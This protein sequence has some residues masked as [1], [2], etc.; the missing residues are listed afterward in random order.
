[1]KILIILIKFKNIKIF[2]LPSIANEYSYPTE[3]EIILSIEFI[4]DGIFL[5]SL[6]PIPN[7]PSLLFPQL[8]T[9]SSS[10]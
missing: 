1:M 3:I 4:F 5:F 9:F 6:S 2:I 7:C 10:K 8:Q